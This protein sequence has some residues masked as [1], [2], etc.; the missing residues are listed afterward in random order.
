MMERPAH[1]EP[2]KAKRDRSMEVHKQKEDANKLSRPTK[3]FTCRGTDPNPQPWSTNHAESQANGKQ[4]RRKPEEEKRPKEREVAGKGKWHRRGHRKLGPK[5]ARVSRPLLETLWARFKLSRYP[6]VQDYLQ[7]SFELSLTDVQ[8][9]QWFQTKR[10]QYQEE[11]ARCRH[12]R[13]RR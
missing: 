10:R 6:R 11:M 9:H 3:D 13:R 8:I 1:D 7:L 5:K 4:K 2:L 12:E